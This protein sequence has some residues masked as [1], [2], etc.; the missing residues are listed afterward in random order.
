[1]KSLAKGI[2]DR[3]PIDLAT[4]VHIFGIQLAAAK[5]ASA[6]TIAASQ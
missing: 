3:N 4:V 1:M 6:A 5:R 2:N